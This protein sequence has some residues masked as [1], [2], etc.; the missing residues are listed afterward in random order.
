MCGYARSCIPQPP[1]AAANQ[2]LDSLGNRL[3]HRLAYRNMGSHEVLVGNHTVDADGTDHAG[4]HWFEIRDPFG[5]PFMQQ[6]NV[7][8]PDA[9]HRWL[10]SI[11]M[12]K[13]GNIGLGYSV[14]S[15]TTFPSIRYTGHMVGDALGTM[16]A[17]QTAF[18][19]TGSQT[20]TGN[21]WGDYSSMNV[22]PDDDLTFWFTQEYYKNS[23]PSQWNTG[24][25]SFAFDAAPVV[26]SDGFESG[27]TTSWSSTTP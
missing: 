14:S 27:D 24:I 13:N 3:L 7:W 21:R 18:V 20:S 23:S 19:G 9:E 2:Y 5:T 16:R 25:V 26:F 6:D 1:P 17:E 22:D 12:D 8:A 10:G 15:A 11:A 4:V